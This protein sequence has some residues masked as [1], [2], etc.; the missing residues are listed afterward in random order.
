MNSIF[1]I[2]PY[3]YLTLWVFDDEKAGLSQ[4]P[5]VSGADEIIDLMVK[6]IPDADKGFILIFSAT[7]FPSHQIE[8]KWQGEDG[9]GN[10]YYAIKFEKEGWL[11]PALFKYF[12]KAP[13]HLYAQAK[14]M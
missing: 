6:D 12:D 4:E 1:V 11:C 5:F 3:K 2:R 10:W 7:P 13:K 14:T 9:G 8:L